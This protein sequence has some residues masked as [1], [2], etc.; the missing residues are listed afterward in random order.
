MSLEGA[1][2]NLITVERKI[3]RNSLLVVMGLYCRSKKERQMSIW[4]LPN[5]ACKS[6]YFRQN[7][8]AFFLEILSCALVDFCRFSKT[9][10]KMKGKCTYI[11]RQIQFVLADT[12]LHSNIFKTFSTEVYS[13]RCLKFETAYLR[14]GVQK[15]PLLF[16]YFEEGQAN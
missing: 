12:R 8:C 16:Y 1:G 15:F 6:I 11:F 4:R 2:S 5:V 3:K 7:V 9:L 10:L 13:Y 14:C